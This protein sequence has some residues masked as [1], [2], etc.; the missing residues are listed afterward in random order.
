VGA[1]AGT[2]LAEQP[3][4]VRLHGVLGDVEL[5]PDL[6]V[7]LAV[8]HAPQ[9]LQLPLGEG[10]PPLR[11]GRPRG[12]GATRSRGVREARP[13]ADRARLTRDPARSA[14]ARTAG[15]YAGVA[16]V[17]GRTRAAGT[18]SA[19]S[20]ADA[21]GPPWRARPAGHLARAR[22]PRARLAAALLVGRDAGRIEAL[23]SRTSRV[24]P[25]VSGLVSAVSAKT[26]SAGCSANRASASGP[27]STVRMAAPSPSRVAQ[28]EMVCAA[29]VVRTQTRTDRTWTPYLS[30]RKRTTAAQ[31][32]LRFAVDACP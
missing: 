18:G 3:P 23:R 12:A 19:A 29:T 31:I 16:P 13:V 11:T 6:R 4:G 25:T 28:V 15:A 20:P 32:N 2:Q 26:M 9:H 27:L 24:K 5:P 30:P 1:V 14:S 17:A 10:Q 7:A 22:L 21:A 8:R